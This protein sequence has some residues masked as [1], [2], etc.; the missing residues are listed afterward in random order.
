MLEA[1]S[2]IGG[3]TAS[4][5]KDGMEVESR[6]HRVLGFYTGFPKLVKKA[7][8]KI[9]DIIIRED[10]VEVKV[11]DGSS[12]IY[13]ASAGAFTH[14]LRRFYRVRIGAFRE[15]M[16]DVPAG[17]IAGRINKPGEPSVL[18]PQLPG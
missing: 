13:G 6:L 11:A 8:L 12:N 7:G 9:S 1:S 3:R 15:G 2:F 4:W 17:P 18:T 16:S 5:N 14:A 10:E